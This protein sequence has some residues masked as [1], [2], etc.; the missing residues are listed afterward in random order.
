MDRQQN[1]SPPCPN[2]QDTEAL[3]H[4]APVTQDAPLAPETTD[5]HAGP[6]VIGTA[7]SAASQACPPEAAQA[8]SERAAATVRTADNTQ[9]P[10]AAA[11]YA[12]QQSG[13][14]PQGGNGLPQDGAF[15]CTVQQGSAAV[16]NPSQPAQAYAAA[17]PQQPQPQQFQQQPQQP[18]QNTYPSQGGYPPPQGYAGAPYGYAPP[19]PPYPTYGGYGYGTPQPPVY[20]VPPQPAY[21]APAYRPGAHVTAPVYTRVEATAPAKPNRHRL[22]TPLF[23]SGICLLLSLSV[24]VAGYLWRESQKPTPVDPANLPNFIINELPENLD[25]GLSAAEIAKRVN[26]SV[27]CIDAKVRGEWEPIG[28][29]SGIVMSDDGYIVT[30]AHVADNTE[31]PE[32]I[33]LV[34]KL[35][36]GRSF[37]A[38]LVGADART[39]LAVLKIKAADL[40]AAEFGDSTQLQVGERVLAIGNAAGEYSGSITQGIISG[41]NRE[42]AF[43]DGTPTSYNLIQTDAAINPGNSGGALVNRFGQVIGISSAKIGGDVYE[44]M[45]FAIPISEAKPI[46]EELIASGFIERATLGITVEPITPGFFGAE[47]APIYGL[48][49]LTVEEASDLNRH[50]IVPG[51]IILSANDRKLTK[52]NDISEELAK[53]KPGD[54]MTLEIQKGGSKKTITIEVTLISSQPTA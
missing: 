26:A 31:Y 20:G 47:D 14:A 24:I 19:A 49:I 16:C 25:D 39:D 18:P 7:E 32:I 48:H 35:A 23:V 5:A 1:Q 38:A 42:L 10:S 3:A 50:D 6:T 53:C 11:Y 37:D 21:A 22:R 28:I 27:V 29:G 34:V 33:G 9:A 12:A 36:D 30:N 13:T 8:Q 40:A 45:G 41:L 43:G 46:V 4:S 54:T 51:D 44:G 15:G 52:T 17:P 2:P